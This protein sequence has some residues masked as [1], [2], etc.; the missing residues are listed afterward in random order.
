MPGSG[1]AVEEASAGGLKRRLVDGGLRKDGKA[2]VVANEAQPSLPGQPAPQPIAPLPFTLAELRACIPEHCF[3]RSALTSLWHTALNL[4]AVA[5][6]FA[7][8][9]LISHEAVPLWARFVLW[10][11]WWYWQGT[12]L[13]GVWVI[14]HE[15]GHQAF[16]E[17]KL[18]NDFVGTILHGVLL[19]PYESWARSHGNHHANTSSVEHDEVFVPP[20]ESSLTEAVKDSPLGNLVQIFVMLAF[21]WCV[22]PLVGTRQ[23]E[24]SDDAISRSDAE[25]PTSS[26]DPRCVPPAHSPSVFSAR[27][28]GYLIANMSGPEKYKGKK[29]DHFRP[30][31]VL[32]KPKDF[33]G[34]VV[35]DAF[36]VAVI[37]GLAY[38][39]L[40][41][42]WMSVLF[43]YFVPYLVVNAYLVGITYLQHTD[44]Y[45]PHYREGAF[46][47][48]RGAIATVDRSWGTLTDIATHH[49]ADTHVCHH[50]FSLMPWYHAQEA[51]EHLKKKL[52]AYY[53][54]D[55]TP[56]PIAMYRSWSRC[57]YIPAEGDIVHYEGAKQA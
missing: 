25:S 40:T 23:A 50:I 26:S 30:S 1:V 29:N 15:C 49:I 11:V 27:R 37:A 3:K 35:S 14:A 43:Y 55:N 4:A 36:L 8:A 33:K 28:P 12:L 22:A 52:G 2:A 41:Y 46:D 20:V 31:S 17:S 38:W 42:G 5:A 9:P 21:G 54:V 7:A 24:S 32:F 39:G 51:T 34:I 18:L 45:I 53:L 13:T 56:I 6:L 19:V 10:P 44:T 48:L 16:S 57:K 47:W